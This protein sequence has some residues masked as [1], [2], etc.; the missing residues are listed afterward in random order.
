MKRAIRFSCGRAPAGA[1][2]SPGIAAGT[3]HRRRPNRRVQS[4]PIYPVRAAP[5]IQANTRTG[6]IR[7]HLRDSA[8]PSAER[9]AVPASVGT[10]PRW[11]RSF[12]TRGSR[13][14]TRADR[15][16]P[17][18]GA[19]AAHRQCPHPGTYRTALSPHTQ[20]AVRRDPW[21]ALAPRTQKR[22]YYQ[23]QLAAR[24]ER[25]PIALLSRVHV[26]PAKSSRLDGVMFRSSIIGWF[27]N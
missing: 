17:P 23:R 9:H 10:P 13:E 4:S 25:Q 12:R 19:G 27:R 24:Y 22:R 3:Y 14:G 26:D 5:Q 18:L 20:A 6:R 16:A 1:A 7:Q 11:A 21:H 8:H 15:L 2:N